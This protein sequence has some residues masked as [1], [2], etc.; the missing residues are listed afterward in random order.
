VDEHALFQS[1]AVDA[2]F[3]DDTGEGRF[4]S[5]AVDSVDLQVLALPGQARGAEQPRRWKGG[6]P[7]ADP[8]VIVK[9]WRRI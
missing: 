6:D 1:E 9:I 4:W 7:L 8:E 2:Q 3:I 5:R